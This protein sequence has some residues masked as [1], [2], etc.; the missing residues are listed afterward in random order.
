MLLLLTITWLRCVRDDGDGRAGGE[1][2]CVD[3]RRAD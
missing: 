1:V 2:T 3:R